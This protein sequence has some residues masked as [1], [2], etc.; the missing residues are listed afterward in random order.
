MA[1]HSG[2]A[3]ERDGDYFGPP[4]NRVARLLSL[5]Q[6]GQVLLSRA[7]VELVRPG[8]G[9]ELRDLG[10]HRLK[11]LDEPEHVFQLAGE[12]LRSHFPPLRSPEARP[13]NLPPQATTL[14]GASASAGTSA[15]LLRRADVRLL[16][17][18]GPGRDRQDPSRLQAAA[19]L[20]AEFEDGAFFV[21]LAAVEDPELVVPTIAH[22]LG[23]RERGTDSLD[24][25]LR[26]HLADRSLLLVAR[27][28]RAGRRC[29]PRARR[30]ARA[31]A[32]LKVVVTSRF[33]LRVSAEREYAVPP[34][35]LPDPRRLPDLVALTQY[36][37]VRLFIERAQAV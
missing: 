27:Q 2:A 36:D 10:V 35:D 34:L 16:T 1:I 8:A 13:T 11:D 22:T 20:L 15:E 24:V 21:A 26:G 7:T 19:E 6:G 31:R 14:I 18:S 30:P 23:L 5:A 28:L 12:G 4:V 37:A 32:G 3:E 17:L 25:A 9:F 33:A 29:G